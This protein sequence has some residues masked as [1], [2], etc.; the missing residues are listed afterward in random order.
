VPLALLQ[1]LALLTLL[2]KQGILLNLSFMGRFT[3]IMIVAAGSM[4]LTW[5]GE[6]IDEYGIGNGISILIFAGIVAGLPTTL[7]QMIFTFDV[8]QIF[9]YIGFLIATILITAGI[10]T[11]T[12]AERLIPVH[13]AK[14]V[15]GNKVYGGVSSYLPLRVNQAGVIPIIFAISILLFPQMLA[16][17][18]VNVQSGV[19]QWM[20]GFL[21]AF[22]ENLWLYGTFY[23]LLVF[24]FTYFYTA[25]TFDPEAISHNLQRSG[26]FVPGIRPGKPTSEYLSQILTRITLVGAIFLGAIAVLPLI[27]QA[28]TGMA[29]LAIGGT[30]LLIVVEVIIDL[31]K[32]V[33]AQVVMRE[34]E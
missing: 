19:I 5:L 7:K 8:S 15:R 3:N 17:M 13:Y 6:L 27:M 1:G 34:Y 33:Q 10:V 18:L 2:E 20:V 28:I 24:F 29:S 32:Q 31:I 14:Q 21:S 22:M 16:N 26:A 25:V 9:L 30:A 11:I 4:L 12:E 23:F